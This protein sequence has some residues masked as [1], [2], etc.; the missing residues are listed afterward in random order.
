MS[1]SDLVINVVDILLV[2]FMIYRL[3]MLVRGTRA[4]GIILGVIGFLV[5]FYVSGRAHLTTVHWLLDKATYLGPVALAVLLLPELRAAI[6]GFGRPAKLLPKIVTSAQED[7]VEART[8][9]ELVAS[10]AELAA[11]RVGALIVI[12]GDSP[13]SDVAANGVLLNARVSAPLLCSIFY[14]G[15]PLHDGAVLING[16]TIVAASCRLP[17]RDRPDH[18]AHMRHDSGIGAS[19]AF[20]CLVIIVSEERGTISVAKDGHLSLIA[21]PLELR[22]LLNRELRSLDDDRRASEPK[23]RR[24]IRRRHHNDVTPDSSRAAAPAGPAA[25]N[26][27]AS[28]A[29]GSSVEP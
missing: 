16:D 19:E 2:T 5:V 4:F 8:V 11:G 26:V 20:D 22:R 13:M 15:N 7:R 10:V 21:S 18:T 29:G 28:A 12:E 14:E 9:E 1:T 17:L 3:L 23:S 25:A 24:V 6:E 27:V